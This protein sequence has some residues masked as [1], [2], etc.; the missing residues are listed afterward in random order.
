MRGVKKL[1]LKTACPLLKVF[2]FF[3]RPETE[4]LDV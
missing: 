4:G 2:W 1:I 3:L